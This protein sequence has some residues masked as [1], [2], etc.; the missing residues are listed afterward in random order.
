M[1][2]YAAKFN[3]QSKT[4]SSSES[5]YHSTMA[6]KLINERLANPSVALTD[7]TI[8]TVANMAAYEVSDFMVFECSSVDM[9]HK[10][11]NGTA[12]SMIVHMNGLERMVNMRGGIEHG[13]FPL[14]VQRM[15][16]W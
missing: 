8:A 13:G 4:S 15:I 3:D 10:S 9:Q 12:A 2:H 1:T 7:E 6:A 11:S 5:L 14:I 16:G